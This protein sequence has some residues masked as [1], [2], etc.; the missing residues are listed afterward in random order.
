MR[1]DG[2]TQSRELKK[3]KNLWWNGKE[4]L[5]W[6]NCWNEMLR[7]NEWVWCDA[8]NG[9]AHNRQQN[10]VCLSTCSCVWPACYSIKCW[11]RSLTLTHNDTRGRAHTLIVT[12]R[13]HRHK[14]EHGVRARLSFIQ[15]K[16]KE[17]SII[18]FKFEFIWVWNNFTSYRIHGGSHRLF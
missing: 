8:T 18:F 16:S 10:K 7:A 5:I 4:R 2:S 17:N 9:R 14:E 13:T 6:L 15:F 1:E 3:K 12:T 11:P